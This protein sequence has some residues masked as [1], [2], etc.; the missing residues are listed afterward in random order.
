MTYLA[1]DF[2]GNEKMFRTPPKRNKHYDPLYCYWVGNDVTYLE[3][4]TIKRLIG[5]TLTWEE[6]PVEFNELME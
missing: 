6:E 2:G 5:R 3:R 1:V 4:G